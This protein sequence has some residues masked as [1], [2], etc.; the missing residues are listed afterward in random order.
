M[1]VRPLTLPAA[2][3]GGMHLYTLCAGVAL[4]THRLELALAQPIAALTCA[5]MHPAGGAATTTTKAAAAVATASGQWDGLCAR[6]WA[7]RE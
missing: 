3:V 4:C 2:G 1:A 6:Y 5:H 7:P